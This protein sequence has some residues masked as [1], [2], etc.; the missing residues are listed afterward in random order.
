MEN[1]H[2][3]ISNS[4][5]PSKREIKIAI[6]TFSRKERIVFSGFCLILVMT[7]ILI[8]ENI[9]QMF[10]TEIPMAGGSI[11]EG[12]IG[13]PRFINPILASS[14]TDRDLASLIYS[15]LMRKSTDGS[16]TTDLAE[17]YNISKDGSSYTF[18]LKDKIYF[19][20]GQ[21]V[22]ADDVIFTIKEVKDPII[23]SP[24]KGNWDGVTVEKKD[25]KTLVFTLKQPY[26]LFLE[27]MT[28][29][30][31][32]AHLWDNTPLELNDANT[33]P[34]GS[35]PYMINA[36]NKQ[37]SGII[38]YY[39]L[40]PFKKF[41]LGEPYIENINL[42]FYQNENDLIKALV[43]KKIE[44][45]SSITPINAEDLKEKN[46]Q[47]ESIVLSRVFGL[48]FNQNAN[49]LF[50]DKNIVAAINQAIDKDKI[51]RDVLLGY[52]VTIDDPIPPNMIKYHELEDKEPISR[53]DLL[54]KA[55]NNLSKDGWKIGADGFLEKTTTEKKKKVVTKLEFSISTG[56]VPELV[57]T[58]ELIKQDLA[59]IGIK[60]DIK[61]FETGNLNQNVIRPR[62]YDALLFGT[63]IN[64]ESDL[65]AFWHSSQRKDPG[66]N[67][68][69]YTNAK[70]DK[71]LEDAFVSLDEQSRI[72]K[73][74]QFS[75]EIKKDMPAVFLYSPD[76]IYIVPKNLKEPKIDQIISP[77]D[78][79]LNVHLWYT[80]TEKVWKIF[81]KTKNKTNTY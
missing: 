33:K 78:R 61:I 11:S 30:I 7:T 6:S 25:D 76:F 23:K 26:A 57:K 44:A 13:T 69:M 74:I 70:V 65:F 54:E 72:K 4:K 35:G 31:M 22:T 52:G 12:I 28:L 10:M 45:I 9:N 34:I 55:Q 21:P 8:L 40:T 79:Y 14:D 24:Y 71:I 38:D 77:S 3:R 47:V 73:Y 42:Y 1:L 39:E 51:V 75:E 68:A 48:F 49:H 60:V 59:V 19:H 5:L 20:D 43:D 29:G 2:N 37:S 27:N 66:L 58:A 53:K 50:T 64:R 16:I 80:Q 18:V 32:P 15:G 17:S 63:I 67:V 56:S 36:V 62:K 81:I 46:Y 41:I